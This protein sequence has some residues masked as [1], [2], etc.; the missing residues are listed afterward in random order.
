MSA[1]GKGGEYKLPCSQISDLGTNTSAYFYEWPKR[2][3]QG[4]LS[5]ANDIKSFHYNFKIGPWQA[6]PT[7]SNICR[8]GFWPLD[9]AGKACQDKPWNSSG[10]L[11]NNE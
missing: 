11:V 7:Y 10:L 9:Y 3:L 2:V 4:R 5:V 1:L 8:L 6:F